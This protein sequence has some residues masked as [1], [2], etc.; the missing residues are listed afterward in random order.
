MCSTDGAG[1]GAG[2]GATALGGAVALGA[3]ST[4]ATL[5]R[6]GVMPGGSCS[7][8]AGLPAAR[9]TIV[10]LAAAAARRAI[11]AGRGRYQGA[12]GSRTGLHAP[13]SAVLTARS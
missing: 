9:T 7:S 13:V 6:L 3:G 4:L 2:G 12:R 5:G 1:G 8:A 10:R 11:A